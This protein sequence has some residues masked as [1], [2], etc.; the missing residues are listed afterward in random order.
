M[1]SEFQKSPTTCYGELRDDSNFEVVC[2]NEDDDLCWTEG[3]PENP[4]FTF[5]NWQEV[6]TILQPY[7][8]SQIWEISAV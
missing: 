2:E 5:K 4:E 3:N 7:F 6:I 8:D 1:E